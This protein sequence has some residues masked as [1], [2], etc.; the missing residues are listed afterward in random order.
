[1]EPLRHR[2]PYRALRVG[3]ALALAVAL[4]VLVV[5]MVLTGFR[6]I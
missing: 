3:V 1:M 5:V 2:W 6:P 4:S